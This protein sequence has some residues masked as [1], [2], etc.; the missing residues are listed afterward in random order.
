[1]KKTKVVCTIGPA[2]EQ[3]DFLE[4]LIG[5]A[6]MNVMR[7]NLS[8]GDHV[9]QG[10]RIKN[11]KALNAEKGWFTGM[12]LDTKGPEIRTGY[13]E[14]D[15]P[16]GDITTQNYVHAEN[17]QMQ[18]D[19]HYFK[20]F[21]EQNRAIY[22]KDI[23]EVVHIVDMDGVFIPDEN[24]HEDSCNKFLYLPDGIHA[25][26]IENASIRNEKKRSVLTELINTHEIK[27]KQKKVPYSI[28]F[29]S[30]NLDHFFSDNANN[31]QK[32][33]SA[34]ELSSQ[35]MHDEDCFVKTVMNTPGCL[36]DM[37]YSDS[38]EFIKESMHSIERH[39]NINILI[40][41]ILNKAN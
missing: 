15:E 14:N 36:T 26:S 3:K 4:K 5:T 19:R 37:D 24:I 7:M 39:S 13:L 40:D 21:L 28:Y 38:W 18:I 11:V 41:R 29:F 31:T 35:F 20:P 16:G 9:E 17:I 33:Q 12:I 22:P 27:V 32:W 25:N 10:F 34:T 6:G 23:Y 1:M 8:H 2:S 30:S